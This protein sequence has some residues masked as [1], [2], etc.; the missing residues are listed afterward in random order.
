MPKCH[1]T[2]KR[3]ARKDHKCNGCGLI[4]N[5]GNEYQ[6]TSGVW[7]KPESFKHCANCWKI[8]ENFN[9]IDKNLLPEDGPSLCQDGVKDWILSFAYEDWHGHDAANDL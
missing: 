2:I 3:K 6:Y 9:A 5:K 8:I 7:D 4:I 1:T